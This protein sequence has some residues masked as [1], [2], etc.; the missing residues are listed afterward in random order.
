MRTTIHNHPLGKRFQHIRG[1]LRHHE[2]NARCDWDNWRDFARDIEHELG[3]PPGPGYYLHRIKIERGWTLN[4][5]MWATRQEV[6]VNT[7]WTKLFTYKRKKW[8]T[9]EFA[10]HLGRNYATIHR[11]FKAGW[12]PRQ[13]E[14]YYGTL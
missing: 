3:L 9:Q 7:K 11:R 13:C 5:L 6:L 14:E 2:P 4:N 12:T 10:D 8:T 1:R